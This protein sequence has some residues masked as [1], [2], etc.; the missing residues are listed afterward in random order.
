VPEGI[1]KGAEGRSDTADQLATLIA[2]RGPAI[3]LFDND[4][5]AV[6]ANAAACRL[7]GRN[8]A[9]IRQLRIDDLKALDNATVDPRH[10]DHRWRRFLDRGSE[11]GRWQLPVGDGGVLLV[12]FYARANFASGLHMSV[13]IPVDEPVAAGRADGDGSAE[14]KRGNLTRRECDVLT[15][16]AR[17]L[18]GV[19]IAAHLSIS[20]PTVES[21][22][23]NA[24]RK[25][26]A[27]NRAHAIAIALHACLI[28]LT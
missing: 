10:A 1:G 8:L 24:M 21:H 25:L 15:L 4:R 27:T 23:G 28:E 6:A 5:R 18:T 17:G 13:F 14:V 9:S 11:R 3:M 12:D 19:E 16:V 22:V 20:P 2:A 7:L 26:G